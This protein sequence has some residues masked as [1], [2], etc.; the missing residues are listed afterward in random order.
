[1][2]FVEGCCESSYEVLC[3]GETEHELGSDDEELGCQS[4]EESHRTFVADEITQ[5]GG[6]GF[7]V[8]E[9]LGLDTRL[10]DSKQHTSTTS[11]HDNAL[12]SRHM[13]DM[14]SRS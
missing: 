6:T 9:R 8:S 1:M 5:H 14:R 12:I 4:F 7:L 10:N 3:D 13:L 2:L 11:T